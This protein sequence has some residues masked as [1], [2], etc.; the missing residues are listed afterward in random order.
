MYN[1]K[2]FGQLVAQKRKSAGLTQEALANKLGISPQAVSKWENGAG[3]P[4]VTLFPPL[5]EALGIPVEQLFGTPEAKRDG[6]EGPEY[7]LGL[8]FVCSEG[9]TGCYSDKTV[10]KSENGEVIFADG[11]KADLR[12]KTSVNRGKGEIRFFDYVPED[13]AE[14]GNV[15]QV[16]KDLDAFISVEINLPFACDLEL[17]KGDNPWIEITGNTKMVNAADVRVV[18]KTFTLTFQNLDKIGKNEW[19]NKNSI[20]LICP[21]EKGKRLTLKMFGSPAC[22]VEPDFESA[23][24]EISGS[25]GVQLGGGKE[26]NVSIFGSGAVDAGSYTGAFKGEIFGSGCVQ[27]HS[28]EGGALISIFGSGGFEAQNIRDHLEAHISGSGGVTASGDVENAKICISG[29][30]AVD[31]DNL[32]TD[33]AN[34]KIQGSGAVSLNEIRT[35]STESLT[36]NATLV[37]KKRGSLESGKGEKN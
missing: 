29:S 12:S 3:F 36:N 32:K 1:T 5:A 33:K 6:Y 26:L 2:E 28:A 27:I 16:Q 10:L 34:I 4:D 22:T 13:R 7:M 35:E 31:G 15:I 25:A 21:F 37:V 11:S 8:P 17:R 30:G 23:S 19:Q 24:I 14:K 9:Q 20:T 18:D